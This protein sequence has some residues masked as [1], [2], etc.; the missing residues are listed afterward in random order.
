MFAEQLQCQLAAGEGGVE[1][2]AQ[3]GAER[4][5]EGFEILEGERG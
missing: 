2:V 3:E 4:T 1:V 5:G